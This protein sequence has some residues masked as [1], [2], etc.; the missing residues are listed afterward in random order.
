MSV[1][2]EN[3]LW[4]FGYNVLL[5]P[6]AMGVLVPLGV[7]LRPALAAGGDGDVVGRGRDELTPAARPRPP[8]RAPHRDAGAASSARS[9]GG[10]T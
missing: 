5:I 9:D 4:A 10:A 1:V 8:A 2:R 3:L 7:T 6:V